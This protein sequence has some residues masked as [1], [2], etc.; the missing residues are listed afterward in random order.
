MTQRVVSRMARGK[1]E[2]TFSRVPLRIDFKTLTSDSAFDDGT[3][4]FE[5]STR[6]HALPRAF[7]SSREARH[8]YSC[9][10]DVGGVAETGQDVGRPRGTELRYPVSA[11]TAEKP[12]PR[13]GPES[14]PSWTSPVRPRSPALFEA[15]A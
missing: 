9:P 13:K 12:L 3:Y 11:T 2:W 8:G 7:H 5:P 4:T 15:R 1:I 6:R 14:F 10:H